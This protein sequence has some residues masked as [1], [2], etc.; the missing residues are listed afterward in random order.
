MRFDPRSPSLVAGVALVAGLLAAAPG[1]AQEDAGFAGFQFNRSLPGARSLAMGGAFVALADDAT[2]AYANPAGLTLLER[3]EVSAEARRWRTTSAIA[4]GGSVGV[5]GDASGVTIAEETAEVDALSFASYVHARRDARWAL[6]AYRHTL[7]DFEADLESAGVV[8]PGGQ[9]L[10]PYRFETDLEL[11]HSG[12]AGSWELSES[13][14]LGAGLS[15]YDFSLD[16]TQTIFADPPDDDRVITRNFRRGDDTDV[17]FNAGLL[18]QIGLD[19]SLGLAYRQGPTFA[20]EQII[21]LG[22]GAELIERGAFE[23]PDQAAAGIAWQPGERLTVIFEYDWV[24]YSALLEANRLGNTPG[25]GGFRLEDAHELRLG[26]EYLFLLD[27]GDSVALMAGAWLDPDHALVFEGGC[28]TNCFR[29]AYFRDSAGDEVHVAAGVGV[30]LG[31]VEVDAA[32]DLS[33]RID[34]FSLST[35]VRF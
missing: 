23:V 17:A 20:I 21:R 10:G 27:R 29:P 5:G 25:G 2:A 24:E 4:D 18:W 26:L 31:A 6:A 11:A 34:T 16:G 15:W 1:A 32:A 14:R 8:V 9:L 12:L 7:A 30:K 19:W 35:V 3:P 22:P 13:L 28:T 33:D